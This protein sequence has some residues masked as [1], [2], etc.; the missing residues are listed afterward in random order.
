MEMTLIVMHWGPGGNLCLLMSLVVW[1][2][3]PLFSHSSL[4]LPAF[5][6][7]LP[8]A[9]TSLGLTVGP[10]LWLPNF[11]STVAAMIK[12]YLK[13]IFVLKISVRIMTSIKLRKYHSSASCNSIAVGG[14]GEGCAHQNS[15][16]TIWV[17]L[18]LFPPKPS[19]CSFRSSAFRK[20]F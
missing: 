4:W 10:M 13:A 5:P 7:L 19:A 3:Q 11:P 8:E 9:A 20:Q 18:K 2:T 6:K 16:P 17:S 15:L 14:W 12:R 1:H